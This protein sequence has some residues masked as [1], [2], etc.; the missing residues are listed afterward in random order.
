MPFWQETTKHGMQLAQEGFQVSGDMSFAEKK[1]K[2]GAQLVHKGLVNLNAFQLCPMNSMWPHH[3]SRTAQECKQ[4]L[5]QV[6][7][8]RLVGPCR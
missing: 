2:C 1:H 4:D 3:P 8:S 5:A 6:S 7:S